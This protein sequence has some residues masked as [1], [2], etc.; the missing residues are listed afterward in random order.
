MLTFLHNF[1]MTHVPRRVSC[2]LRREERRQSR[3]DE[4]ELAYDTRVRVSGSVI[5]PVSFEG[6][7]SCKLGDYMRL[8]VAQY[9]AIKMPLDASLTRVPNAL[10][11]FELLVPPVNFGL[12]FNLTVMPSLIARVTG[13]ESRVLIASDN[14]TISGSP[15]VERL[16]LNEAR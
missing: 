7:Q 4:H 5:Q 14:C 1:M 12:G 11:E 9:A 15:L 6:G 8:P 2:L 16:S 13:E 10:D 3:R